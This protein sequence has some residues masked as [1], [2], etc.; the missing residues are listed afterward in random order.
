L[1]A[2]LFADAGALADAAAEVVQ[3]RAV[4]V[5]DRADLDPLDLRR[6]QRE[7]ALDADTERLLPDGERLADAGALALDHDPLEHLDAAALALDHLE[8]D[9]HGVPRLELGHLA[10]LFAL[11]SL[12]RRAHGKG[13]ANDGGRVAAIPD[14]SA[15]VASR[16]RTPRR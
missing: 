14:R 4:D 16:S 2:R 1:L 3:L 6:V 12:D 15:E 7:R 8:M 13:V 11:E 9:A 10:Q 5:A